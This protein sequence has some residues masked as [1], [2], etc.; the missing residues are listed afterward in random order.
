MAV[1]I[2]LIMARAA[3]GCIGR[4]NLIPWKLGSDMRLFKETTMGFPMVMGRSTWESIGKPL[5]G[6]AS[7][8]LS[9]SISNIP[10]TFVFNSMAQLKTAL[11]SWPNSPPET[12]LGQDWSK[13]N[14]H[15][16]FVIGGAKVYD[17]FMP[18][19]D[20]LYLTSVH[21][22]IDGDTFMG[23][24]ELNEWRIFHEVEFPESD[25]DQYGFTYRI[26]DRK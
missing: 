19:C 25:S 16:I 14:W 6:R 7:L 15:E 26:L 20:R 12:P 10:G 18:I 8:V 22:E 21:A 17:E 3:N 9:S 13:I 11:E 1:K 24:I 23:P 5:P 4:D 2:N